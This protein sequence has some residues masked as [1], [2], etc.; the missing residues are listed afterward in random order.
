[1]AM[2]SRVVV[3]DDD[4]SWADTLAGLLRDRGLG[5]R[6]A[7][8]GIEGYQIIEATRPSLIILDLNLPRMSGI[9]L[10]AQLR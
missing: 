3:V 8:D 4:R 5:V 2:T 7:H 10:L 6:L 9:Q 1:M